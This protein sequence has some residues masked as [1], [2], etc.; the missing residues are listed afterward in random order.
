MEEPLVMNVC[1]L[2]VRYRKCMQAFFKSVLCF[3]LFLRNLSDII[4]E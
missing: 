3:F 2:S 1:S 4:I